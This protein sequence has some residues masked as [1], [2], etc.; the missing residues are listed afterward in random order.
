MEEGDGQEDVKQK[1]ERDERGAG[2]PVGYV[3]PVLD[4]HQ[5]HEPGSEPGA[6]DGGEADHPVR[7][8]REASRF[9]AE[10]FT[11]SERDA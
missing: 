11:V 4:E 5:D 8:G 2:V 9:L 1:T 3:Q 6:D 10:S 7:F